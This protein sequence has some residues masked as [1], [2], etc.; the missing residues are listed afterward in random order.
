M[1]E[2]TQAAIRKSVAVE[3]AAKAITHPH[4]KVSEGAGPDP[5]LTDP[6]WKPVSTADLQAG[7]EVIVYWWPYR[8]TIRSIT[9][10]V[11]SSVIGRVASFDN[12]RWMFCT[13]D[14]GLK[15]KHRPLP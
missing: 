9:P 8:D 2:K 4:I 1:D 6:N 10:Y 12:G 14:G 7:D 13:A 3:I 5:Y 15:L 11:N